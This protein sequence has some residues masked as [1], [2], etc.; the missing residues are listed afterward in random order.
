MKKVLINKPIHEDAVKLLSSEVEVLTPY[1]APESEVVAMLNGVEGLI[2]CAGMNVTASVLDQVSGLEVIGRHGAGIDIVDLDAATNKGI[3]VTFTPEGPTESTAEHAAMLMMASAR[4][5]SYLDRATR[6]GNFHVRDVVVGT[7]LL[8]KKV[9]VAGFG[10][11]GQ[12]FAEICRD[13][14]K[15]EIHAYDP[16]LTPDKIKEWGAVPHASLVEL[17][18]AVDFLS[19]H[20]PLTPQTRHMINADVFKALG[21]KG[22]FINCSRGPVADEKALTEALQNGTIAG[23]GL[24]VF[25]PEPPQPDNPLF[26]MDNVV[27]TPHLASFTDEG[28]RR[29][30]LMVAEDMLRVLRGEM[31]KYPANPQVLKK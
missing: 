4:K 26:S 15:M 3:L 27:F 25:D 31:P 30:G 13:A 18:E 11:I 22:F 28:R 5:L 23:A 10:H 24:D 21:S 14:F 12:R 8:E 7:E 20:T 29:M 17:A 6:N 1:K 2:L 9:G 16:F 19:V